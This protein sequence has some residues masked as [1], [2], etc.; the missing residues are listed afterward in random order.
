MNRNKY[1][2]PTS[3]KQ[4]DAPRGCYLP[5]VLRTLGHQIGSVA[6][7]DVGVLG[8]DVY[9]LEEVV[10]HVPEHEAQNQNLK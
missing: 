5:L 4:L 6:I 3:N 8:V 1:L 2:Q 9:V 7:Q 10:K